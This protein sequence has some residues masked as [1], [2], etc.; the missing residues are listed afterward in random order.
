MLCLHIVI[1][2]F[3][4]LIKITCFN[5]ASTEKKFANHII[6]CAFGVEISKAH[7][8]LFTPSTPS[9]ILPPLTSF[10]WKSSK[11]EISHNSLSFT[12]PTARSVSLASKYEWNQSMDVTSYILSTTDRYLTFVSLI[13]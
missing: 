1:Q 9:P 13:A 6:L 7:F 5:Q 10:I 4:I 11:Y 3:S 8:T 2:P 12:S